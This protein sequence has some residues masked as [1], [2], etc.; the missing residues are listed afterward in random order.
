MFVHNE[1]R[2]T[3]IATI[4]HFSHMYPGNVKALLLSTCW[5]NFTHWICCIRQM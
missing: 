1:V 2:S 3:D 5:Q 4:V